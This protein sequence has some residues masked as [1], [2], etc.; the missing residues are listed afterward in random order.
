[1][2]QSSSLTYSGNSPTFNLTGLSYTPDAS[3][4]IGGAINHQTGGYACLGIVAASFDIHGTGSLFANP[5]SQCTQAGLTD[6]PTS[7]GGTFVRAQ[8]VK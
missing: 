7:I 2:T 8:L 5:T 1:M 4:T 3:L 6:L